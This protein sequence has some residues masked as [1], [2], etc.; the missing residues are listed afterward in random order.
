MGHFP[1]RQL[2]IRANANGPA[3]EEIVIPE[4]LREFA[5]SLRGTGILL[6]HT[7]AMANYISL[8]L[9]RGRSKIPAYAPFS[10]PDV[11]DAPREIASKE[12]QADVPRWM[13]RFRQDKRDGN[14]QSI[15][16]QAWLLYH[17]GFSIAAD[18]AGDWASFGGL[19]ARLNHLSIAMNIAVTDSS[20]MALSY[21]RLVREFL[22]ESP[23]PRDESAIGDTFFGDFLSFWE[24]GY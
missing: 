10:A 8:E 17:L 12:H 5:V 11:S 22:A 19:A 21:D 2:Q 7:Q 18:I 15:P 13:A 20:F 3:Y 4:R 24:S 23:R 9:A 14:P 6:K 1:P 16:M